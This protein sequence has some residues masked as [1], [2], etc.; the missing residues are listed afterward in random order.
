MKNLTPIAA[1]LAIAGACLLCLSPQPGRAAEIEEDGEPPQPTFGFFEAATLGFVE[2]LTEYLPVSSTGHLIL[3]AH[4]LDLNH[5]TVLLNGE[6][7][8]IY[9]DPPSPAS[10][11][12]TPLTYDR[13]IDGFLIII[14]IG[15]IAAVILLYWKRLISMFW[16]ILG[17]SAEGLKLLRNLTLAFIPAALVG[18]T[19]EET[20]DR[21]LFGTGPVILALF[22]G[23]ILILIV[24]RWHRN[25]VH[26]QDLDLPGLTPWN[27]LFIGLLQCF[28]LWPGT[29]RSLMTILGGYLV[30]L[31]P[32]K[33]AEFSFLLGLV[34]L[35]AASLYKGYK[36]GPAI[37]HGFGWEMP[38]LAC[39][40]GAL[41][42]AVAVKWMVAYLS[43][44][45]LAIF[46]I[47]RIILS[48][49]MAYLFY[50]MGR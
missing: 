8:P 13:A 6:G 37:I 49:L 39:L 15:A 26:D 36:L 47:Y 17:K 42:A 31:S 46:G 33:A 3:T 1:R 40:V 7:D 41:S 38:L 22:S 50:G 45:G 32:A 4:L 5:D 29:S 9:L 28:A 30:R 24:D 35:S 16:G 48:L 12:G 10:P 27:C 43:K 34:T 25:Q 44:H 11:R 2:G 19:L 21:H 18:L 23:G 20:I 14:Q